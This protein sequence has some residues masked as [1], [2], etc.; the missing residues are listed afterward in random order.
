MSCARV[1]T[2]TAAKISAAEK[3]NE[4]K[5]SDYSNINVVPERIPM[6]VHFKSPGDKTYMQILK[7]MEAEGK[8]SRRGLR[9]DAVLFDEIIFDVNTIYFEE[10]G[11]YEYA[12]KF[13]AEAYHYACE[14]YG[15][16]NIISAVM[17]ADEINKAVSDE[18]GHPVY[19]YHMHLIALPVVEKEIRWSKRC[20]DPALVGTVK[21]VIRQIS[22]SKKWESREPLLTESGEPIMRKNGKP[23]F[24][25]SYSI[26][27]DEFFRHM[28]DHGFMGFDRGREGSTAEHL[29]SLQ[30]Q[31]DKDKERLAKIESNIQKAK[32]EYEP[33]KGISKTFQEIE[34][35]GKK[36]P[37][38]G[39]YS[40][41]KEDYGQLVSLAK[42]GITSRVK[43]HDL[44]KKEKHLQDQANQYRSAFNRLQERYDKLTEKC[45]PFL[46]GLEHFPDVVQRFIEHI[47]FLLNEKEKEQR[48]RLPI[49]R[50]DQDR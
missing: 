11:G 44:R 25:P 4:R 9:A 17:H 20:K 48:R 42:E 34:T 38:T 10:R 13:F 27:Q 5:N 32:I 50:S 45:R 14:K 18:V 1:Q 31:I 29:T 22:H 8:V 36:N 37:L 3:H 43:I 19:H 15:E 49:A 26:L 40:V 12:T 24:R 35:A 41:T 47:S 46:R 39:N 33:V 7:D 2:Y 16:E 23:K 30:Y 6:N 21:E 28:T